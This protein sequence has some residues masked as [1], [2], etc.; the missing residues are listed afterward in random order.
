MEYFHDAQKV[1]L[2]TFH[3]QYLIAEGNETVALGEDGSSTSA[4]WSVEVVPDSDSVLRLKS[5]YGKYLAA[6]DQPSLL[7]KTLVQFAGSDPSQ[8]SCKVL[9]SLPRPLDSSLEW[10]P[11]KEATHVKL[12]TRRGSFLNGEP[13]HNPV[14]HD[15]FN[16]TVPPDWVFW[17]VVKSEEEGSAAKSPCET[18]KGS[19][20]T[21]S[22]PGDSGLTQG[23]DLVGL[24]DHREQLINL[25]LKDN[26]GTTDV[27]VR[28]GLGMTA[29]VRKVCEDVRTKELFHTIAWISVPQEYDSELIREEILLQLLFENAP[30]QDDF[31]AHG[32]VV[33]DHEISSKYKGRCLIVV[34]NLVDQRTWNALNK[35]RDSTETFQ[36]IFMARRQMGPWES[37]LQ[38]SGRQLETYELN[39]DLSEEEPWT[40]LR[41][42]SLEGDSPSLLKEV[43][44]LIVRKFESMPAAIVLHLRDRKEINTERKW[45][46]FPSFERNDEWAP[47]ILPSDNFPSFNLI[48]Q[49]LEILYTH[50]CRF[51]LLYLSIFPVNI[52]ISCKR[53]SRLWV[54]E[55]CLPDLGKA[56]GVFKDLLQRKCIHPVEERSDGELSTFRVDNL[57]QEIIVSSSN[58]RNLVFNDGNLVTIT[59][60]GSTNQSESVRY[61]SVQGAIWDLSEKENFQLS[62]IF[63]LNVSSNADKTATSETLPLKTSETPWFP[64]ELQHSKV[65]DLKG[66]P[67]QIAPDALFVLTNV[68]Y[69]S[70][71]QTSIKVIPGSIGILTHLEFLD[72]KHS[73]VTELPPEFARLTKIRHIL[74]YHHEKDRMMENYNLI[75]FK[76]SCN[77]RGFQCLEKLCFVESNKRLLKELQNLTALRRLGI[78]KLRAEH[79]KLLCSSLQELRMLKSLNIH[80][81]DGDEII[82][83]DDLS[84]AELHFLKHL[85]LHGRLKNLPTRM[86]SLSSLTR[87][88]LRWSRLGEGLL[89]ILGSLPSLVELELRRAFDG[90]QLEFKVGQFKELKILLL[91]E[92]D[93]LISMSLELGTLPRLEELTISRCQ[94]LES[95]PPGIEHLQKIRKLT[96]FDMSN[97]FY[98]KV[99]ADHEKDGYKIFKPIQEVYLTRWRAGHWKGTDEVHCSHQAKSIDEA[100]CSRQLESTDGVCLS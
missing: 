85:Y 42:I 34:D 54:A 4:W 2:Q 30:F 87:I 59:G 75:G 48:R 10:E 17:D 24:H 64:S 89:V 25:L 21:K 90:K 93:G 22:L 94:W 36:V 28:G 66:A 13:G 79:C 56:E 84:L 32:L 71:R 11:V 77:V 81:Y 91:D 47:V 9:Q 37:P 44:Q 40:H 55:G 98:D 65:L 51:C 88:I 5:C 27:C 8:T 15:F 97:K 82:Y 58:H 57:V 41:Q 60:Q 80:A 29:L 83:L 46:I 26:S 1:R 45:I 7:S 6:S 100:Y 18:G 3:Q 19:S 69:L 33:E 63:A 12:R 23:S 99:R 96:F 73:L 61:R 67:I 39:E 62:S 86:S 74:I 20:V 76:A 31:D 92:L 70:L 68:R 35:V 72:A 95:I 16:S 43:C 38:K 53:V 49:V 50:D 78:T 52:P 14:T